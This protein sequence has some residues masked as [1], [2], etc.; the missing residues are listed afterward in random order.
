MSTAFALALEEAR[1]GV[2]LNLLA[3]AMADPNAKNPRG[4]SGNLSRL[5]QG[6]QE[7]SKEKVEQIVSALAS[8]RELSAS[9][10]KYWRN[11]LMSAAGYGNYAEFREQLKESESDVR[12]SLRP[13]CHKALQTVQTLKEHEIRT[14]LDHV[15]VSTMKLIIAAAERCEEIEV[16]QL[17]KISAELQQTAQRSLGAVVTVDADK[18]DTVIN[19]GRARILIDGEVS[20]AQMQV[21]ESAAEMIQS[22]LKL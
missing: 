9:E 4:P 1:S 6:K 21:L 17:Q 22:V 14:I 5:Q 11:K 10:V 2:H 18:A 12:G 3:K 15:E 8:I 7:P 20:P 19:A 16:V 13:A